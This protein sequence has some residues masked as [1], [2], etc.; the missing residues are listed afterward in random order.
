MV[1]RDTVLRHVDQEVA[2]LIHELKLALPYLHKDSTD[3]DIKEAAR[4]IDSAASS[5]SLRRL[6]YTLKSAL[7]T[8]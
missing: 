6:V 3:E 2:A 5:H 4:L 8:P 7:D 1:K